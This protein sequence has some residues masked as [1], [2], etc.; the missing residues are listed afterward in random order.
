MLSKI[1]TL[2]GLL[3]GI[4]ALIFTLGGS[5]PTTAAGPYLECREASLVSAEILS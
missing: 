4:A 2:L 5:S 1:R 3:F